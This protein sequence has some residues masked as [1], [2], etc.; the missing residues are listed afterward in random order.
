MK[1]IYAK[2]GKLVKKLESRIRDLPPMESKATLFRVASGEDA[3]SF[4]PN[5][6][7]NKTQAELEHLR[8]QIHTVKHAINVFNTAHS[9]PGFDNLTIDQA[10]VYTPQLS[11]RKEI[12]RQ[13][14]AHLPRERVEDS[15]YRFGTR[16]PFIDYE[17]T[18]YDT[19]AARAAYSH[20]RKAPAYTGHR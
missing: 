7:F 19:A 20:P 16:T 3:D 6:D 1:Y 8:E 5:Y 13:M 12:L 4:R 14:A 10:L 9:L 18:N 15:S 17:V 2:A 11:N